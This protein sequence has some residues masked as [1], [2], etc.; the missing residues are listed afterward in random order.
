MNVISNVIYVCTHTQLSRF[1]S[2]MAVKIK[3]FE[4]GSPSAA[5]KAPAGVS[6]VASSAFLG[7]RVGNALQGGAAVLDGDGASN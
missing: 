5:E 2:L 7:Q 4:F 6:G 1:S 3:C